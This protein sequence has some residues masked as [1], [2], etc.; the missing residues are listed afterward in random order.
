VA[1]FEVFGA[2]VAEAQ[3]AQLLPGVPTASLTGL[4]YATAHGLVDLH[5]GGP[6]KRERLQGREAGAGARAEAAGRGT[7][8]VEDGSVKATARCPSAARSSVRVRKHGRTLRRH[9]VFFEHR[10]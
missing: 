8:E 1:A 4:L 9:D 10:S 5:I 2:I 6:A 7:L 3:A